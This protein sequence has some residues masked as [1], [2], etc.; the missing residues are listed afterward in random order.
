MRAN[1]PEWELRAVILREGYRMASF[2]SISSILSSAHRCCHGIFVLED[3]DIERGIDMTMT[4][5]R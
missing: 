1:A 2:V 3:G 4:E 5:A